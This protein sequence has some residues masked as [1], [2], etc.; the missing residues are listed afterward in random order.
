MNTAEQLRAR[1]ASR[2]AAPETACA[3]ESAP[4]PAPAATA[5]TSL[6]RRVAPR[7]ANSPFVPDDVLAAAG[8][9]TR[10]DIEQLPF[11]AIKCDDAGRV[12]LYNTAQAQLANMAVSAVEGK[13]F[14]TQVA[15][16]CNNPL[17]YGAFKRGVAADA[18]NTSFPYT[19]TYKMKPTNV[20]V[21]LFRDATTKANWIFIKAG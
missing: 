21:H 13:N 20:I 4:A 9:L 16:C 8:T 3:P 6:L 2:R 14:F 11:G 12:L 1:L 15:L 19:F 10:D 17:F 18:L 7:P 5:P